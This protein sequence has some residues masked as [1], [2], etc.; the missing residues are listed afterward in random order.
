MIRYRE[1]EKNE[2]KKKELFFFLAESREI[3]SKWGTAELE[4]KT[5]CHPP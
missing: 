4:N 3:I 2:L 5:A 1:K